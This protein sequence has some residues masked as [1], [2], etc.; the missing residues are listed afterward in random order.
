MMCRLENWNTTCARFSRNMT[1]AG[2]EW[3]CGLPQKANAASGERSELASEVRPSASGP[4]NT[5]YVFRLRLK[6]NSLEFI[7]T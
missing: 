4:R 1:C 5:R 3:F 6:N 2:M 7:D